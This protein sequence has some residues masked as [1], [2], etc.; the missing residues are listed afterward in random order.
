MS[1]SERVRDN[2][3]LKGLGKPLALNAVDWKVKKQN[4][5][6]TPSEVRNETLELVRY[7][8]DEGLFRLGDVHVHR[9]FTWKRPLDRSMDKISH[10]YVDHYDDPERWMFSAWL[11]LTNKG[12]Q[13]AQ[14]LEAKAI[15]YYRELEAKQGLSVDNVVTQ[16]RAG[17]AEPQIRR[18]GIARS[19]A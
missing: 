18:D 13:L 6:A 11:K 5:C 12:E 1:T 7:L 4:P 17:V 3:L 14:S 2:L 15:D 10:R 9:F 16:L 19:V 8:V